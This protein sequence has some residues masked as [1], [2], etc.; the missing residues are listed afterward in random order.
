MKYQ[1]LGNSGLRVSEV[2]LGTMTF[3]TETGWG[4]DQ[5]VSRQMYALFRDAGGNFVDTANF[6]TN[7]SSEQFLGEFIRGHRQQVVLATKYT[8]AAPGSDPNAGGNQRK[9]MVQSVEA[10]LKRLKTDYI[11]LYW[12]HSWDFFTPVEEIMRGLDDLVRQGKILYVGVSDAPAWAVA[13]ANMLASL[14]GWTPFVGLQIEYNLAQRTPERE[15]LPLAHA[16]NLSVLAWSPLA[17]GLLTG[18]YGSHQANGSNGGAK[19]GQTSRGTELTARNLAIAQ[20]VQ[21]VADAVGGEP[22]QV[23]LRWLLDRGII[24]ILGGTKVPQI[25]NNLKSLDLTLT[26]AQTGQLNEA[27]RIELGFPHDFLTQTRGYT[28]GGQFD[29]IT[30]VKKQIFVTA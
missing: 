17:G 5:A 11:D 20:A 15:L 2:C 24:P 23:A 25:E 28:F 7:G 3:G 16:R 6:Y 30:T 10:S 19:A 22:S 18:K 1:L 14:R 8:D 4:A 9:N 12:V 26:A 27:S 29:N 13:E 21:S